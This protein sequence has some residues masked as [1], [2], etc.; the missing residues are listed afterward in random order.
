M[1]SSAEPKRKPTLNE[2]YRE[3]EELRRKAKTDA[4]YSEQ[5]L[6]SGDPHSVRHSIDILQCQVTALA[7]LCQTRDAFTEYEYMTVVVDELRE[8]VGDYQAELGDGV[9]LA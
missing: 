1:P 7:E 3:R 9:T 4:H 6:R 2:L 5:T 8:L